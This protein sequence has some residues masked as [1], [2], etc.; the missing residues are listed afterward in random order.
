[1]L[2]ARGIEGAPRVPEAMV[3]GLFAAYGGLV[4]AIVDEHAS[5]ATAAAITLATWTGIAA[6]SSP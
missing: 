2:L 5:L 4:A 1:M 6:L 3:L